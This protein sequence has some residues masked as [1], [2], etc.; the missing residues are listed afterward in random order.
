MKYLLEEFGRQKLLNLLTDRPALELI[1]ASQAL[2]HRL[3]VGSDVKGVLGDLPRY[4]RHVRG[5]PRKDIC[6]GT[7]EVDEHHFLFAVEGG[8]DLQRPWCSR[9][10]RR[11][12][13]AAARSPWPLRPSLAAA[14]RG[15]RRA[16]EPRHA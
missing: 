2:L 5:A 8:A 16:P 3:G 14:Q 13:H 9:Q 10:A 4:A 6:V 11:C 7:E 12:S 1:K 15:P